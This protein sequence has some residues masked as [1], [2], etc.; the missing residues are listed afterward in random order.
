MVGAQLLKSFFRAFFLKR[1]VHPVTELIQRG[2]HYLRK[3][4]GACQITLWQKRS[5]ISVVQEIKGSSYRLNKPIFQNYSFEI[6]FPRYS[7]LLNA[8]LCVKGEAPRSNFIRCGGEGKADVYPYWKTVQEHLLKAELTF[9]FIRA[10][11]PFQSMLA[12]L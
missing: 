7:N 6:T 4:S 3:F 9:T 11:Q 1:H 8:L 2:G 10:S 12:L 5:F